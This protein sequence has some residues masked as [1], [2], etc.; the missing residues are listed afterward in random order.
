VRLSDDADDQRTHYV[1][2][3]GEDGGRIDG[4][5]ADVL[6]HEAAMTMPE[7]LGGVEFHPFD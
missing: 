2:V 4:A 6:A 3:K 5:V 7:P 1:L